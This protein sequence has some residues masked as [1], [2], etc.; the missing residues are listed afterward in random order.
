MINFY[1]AKKFCKDKISEIEN[2]DKAISDPN[3]MWECHHRRETL[4]SKKELLE[5]NEY[6]KRPASELI[7]LTKKE[8]RALHNTL[9]FKGK[10]LP[11]EHKQKMSEA[12]KGKPLSEEHKQKI[13]NSLK[14]NKNM[15]GKILS[16][17]AKQKLSESRKGRCWFNNGIKN[18]FAR[19]CPEGFVK[20]RLKHN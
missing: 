10:T 8:H 1:N 12:H 20:G 9:K 7:F 14:G 2:Y 3:Q 6:F 16:E 13:S 5:N 15:R 4:V 19:E 17:E 18:V 11:E